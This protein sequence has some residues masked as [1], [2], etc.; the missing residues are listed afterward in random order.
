M[1]LNTRCANLKESKKLQKEKIN[2]KS[3]PDII[4][5]DFLKVILSFSTFLAFLGVIASWSYWSGFCSEIGF[6]ETS[7]H[8]SKSFQ[9]IPLVGVMY[10]LIFILLF[11][12]IVKYFIINRRVKNPKIVVPL[13]IFVFLLIIA[14]SERHGSSVA[15][16]IFSKSPISK[17]KANP[18]NC[19]YPKVNLVT[20]E[21]IK[22]SLPYTK[23][24]YKYS[25]TSNDAISLRYIF[26]DDNNF[27]FAESN[28]D[29]LKPQIISKNNIDQIY[30]HHSSNIYGFIFFFQNFLCCS[31][32]II[33]LAFCVCLIYIVP[34]KILKH[35]C[36]F[37]KFFSQKF[38]Q[39][40]VFPKFHIF[41]RK[42][43]KRE[44]KIFNYKFLLLLS[45]ILSFILYWLFVCLLEYYLVQTG[46]ILI[47]G[48]V[49]NGD[50]GYV[51]GFMN[52]SFM[53]LFYFVI[54]SNLFQDLI[55]KSVLQ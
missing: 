42:V 2:K 7:I 45:T 48:N 1:R 46:L 51:F 53:F 8:F 10:V 39:I 37:I 18:F 16:S 41:Y 12:A 5:I 40:K 11:T 47:F 35:L 31:Y 44:K 54:K 15:N 29:T 9:L 26:S 55:S 25:Y 19:K 21:F 23:Q 36:I 49:F 3:L 22:L 43:I 33:T 28:I 50:I 17:S 13:L 14:L 27:Y 52:G 24:N 6:P 32:F 20:H 34:L 4:D 38:P 30:Y